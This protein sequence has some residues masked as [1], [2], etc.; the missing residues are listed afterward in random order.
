MISHGFTF[1]EIFISPYSFRLLSSFLSFHFAVFPSAFLAGRSSGNRHPQLCLTGSVLISSLLLKDSFTGYRI[2]D[3]Q[4]SS[5]ILNTLA[6]CFLTSKVL[7]NLLASLLRVP[8][9][10]KW[11]ISCC[12]QDSL[13]VSVR[14]LIIMCF[15]VSLWVP[16]TVHWAAWIVIL[17]YFIQL[18]KSLA[19]I[20]QCSLCPFLCPPLGLPRVCVGLF[21]G[22]PWII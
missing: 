8:C 3:W 12:G 22:I 19:I 18:G 21:N 10:D 13:I 20:S 15:C 16:L 1:F 2:L 6:H 17:M 11:L 4:F 7:R 14:S 9:T 5:S